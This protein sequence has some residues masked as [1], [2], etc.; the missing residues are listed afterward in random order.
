MQ[1]MPIDSRCNLPKVRIG[2]ALSDVGF[3]QTETMRLPEDL[4]DFFR[5]SK[6]KLDSEGLFF[7]F[8]PETPWLKKRDFAYVINEENKWMMLGRAAGGGG[9]EGPYGEIVKAMTGAGNIFGVHQPIRDMDILS[10]DVQKKLETFESVQQAMVFAHL[11]SADYFVFHL[12]QSRDY[13]DWNRSDQIA[14]A[15][16]AFQGWAEFYKKSGFTF[17]PLLE[18]LEFPK[19]PST[20][21]EIARIHRVCKKFLPNLKLCLDIPHLWRSRSLIL[22]N[23]EK[24]RH[25]VP[26]FIILTSSFTD[27]LDYAFE[28]VFT[29]KAG[30]LPDD[31]HLYHMAGCWKHLTHEILGLRP[32]ESPFLHRLRLN[33]P[34]YTYDQQAEMVIPKVIER[35]LRYKIERKQDTRIILETY[36]RNYIEMLEAA[37]IISEEIKNKAIRIAQK[38]REYAYLWNS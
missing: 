20:P 5:L 37:K 6:D 4:L 12:A 14:I 7:E 31:L 23:G 32:G 28:E 36:Q 1:E 38:A 17:T 34:V 13:W 8:Q 25:A 29:E 15:I 2:L 11:V 27:Y 22:E 9:L 24:V 19:F 35:L 21:E 10:Q 33:D 26:D 3:Y 16:K 30:L 18:N